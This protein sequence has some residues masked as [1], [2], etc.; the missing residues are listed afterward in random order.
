MLNNENT[1]YQNPWTKEDDELLEDAEKRVKRLTDGY[2]SRREKIERE[3]EE[4]EKK[5]NEYVE[6]YNE[7]QAE[8]NQ[9]KVEINQAIQENNQSWAKIQRSQAEFDEMEAKEREREKVEQLDQVI[10]PVV[11]NAQPQEDPKAYDNSSFTKTYEKYA[12]RK[13][14]LLGAYTAIG[15][16]YFS[17][18][19]YLSTEF[20]KNLS[21]ASAIGATVGYW[22]C[23]TVLAGAGYLGYQCH[24]TI[25]AELSREDSATRYNIYGSTNKGMERV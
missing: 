14:C 6:Q 9:M 11:S 15:L 7:V 2:R 20:A 3:T 17:A 16:T 13:K 18:G 10:K 24:E 5:I 25:S 23:S 12:F 1:E 22:A 4:N 21:T 8:I 19:I